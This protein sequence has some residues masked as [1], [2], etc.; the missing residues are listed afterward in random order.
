MTIHRVVLTSGT[1]ALTGSNYFVDFARRSG[2]FQWPTSHAVR[3]SSEDEDAAIAAWKQSLGQLPAVELGSLAS[4][5][6]EC[7][8]V[9]A[10]VRQKTLAAEP[11][12]AIVCSDT[13][14]GYAAALLV[15][16][17]LERALGARVT[18]AQ[19][20]DL[21]AEA[22]T[23]FVRSLGR[24]MA[25]VLQQLSAGVPANTCFAPIGGYKVMS[26][27]G[28]VAGSA[29][30]YPMA[31][32][33]ERTGV[34]HWIPP[35]PVQLDPA[36]ARRHTGVFRKAAKTT[37][38]S[39]L[40]TDEQKVVDE[41]PFFFERADDLVALGAYGIFAVQ[42]VDPSA[43]EKRISLSAEVAALASR[44]D[45]GPFVR[46]ELRMLAERLRDPTRHAAA[47]HHERAFGL[48]AG[49]VAL[50]KGSSG[51]GG[52]LRAVYAHNADGDELR[53]F[54]VWSNHDAYEREARAA[55]EATRAA[56]PAT[57]DAS[58][59]VYGADGR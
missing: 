4:I 22:R 48:E 35:I 9:D 11:D 26:A 30:G 24:F 20:G 3:C 6:A 38:W 51:D 18:I 47:L 7:A 31:Y 34:L 56:P 44:A 23:A 50:Y 40:S 59:V 53:V 45:V 2:H 19:S 39:S 17:V 32:V 28:Y 12:V 49:V 52:V 13:F 41:H 55:V 43:L 36:I 15:A 16:R 42:Q 33:H 46:K 10:L 27:L 1:S 8:V 57:S 37:L 21:D 5:S 14:S 29:G 54:R 58:A 25:D